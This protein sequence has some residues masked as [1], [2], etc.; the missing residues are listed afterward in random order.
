[1][2]RQPS[3]APTLWRP[4]G[5]RV[6]SETHLGVVWCESEWTEEWELVERRHDNRG[7]KM[8][9]GKRTNPRKMTLVGGW[10]SGAEGN[11]GPQILMTTLCFSVC[12]LLCTGDRAKTCT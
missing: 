12:P 9:K 6:I 11:R 1:M 8:T 10:W 4:P 3:S 2:A 7:K 5:R